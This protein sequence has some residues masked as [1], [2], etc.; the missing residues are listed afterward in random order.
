MADRRSGGARRRRGRRARIETSAGGVVFRRAPA[1]VRVLLIRDPYENWG[2]PKGHLEA[3]E[4]PEQAALREVAEETG[5]VQL[6]LV[7]RLPTI[8]WYFRDRG[9][10][11]HKF[12]HFYL[13][14]SRTGEP[15]PQHDEGITACVWCGIDA[16]LDRVSYAN[17][18]EVIRAAGRILDRLAHGEAPAAADGSEDLDLDDLDAALGT[19]RP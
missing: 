12:C 1:D 4:T 13:V 9:R 2:L 8:D 17:A 14:E 11:I 3:D 19:D 5:L 18:R 16:A 7:E 6:D 10:L 15:V